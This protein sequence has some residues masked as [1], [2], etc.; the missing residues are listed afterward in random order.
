MSTESK[1]IDLGKK[2]TLKE[3]ISFGLSQSGSA[4]AF[5]AISSLVTIFWTD[6]AGVNPAIIA[7]VIIF[8]KILDAISNIVFGFLIQQTK[9]KYG[10]ARPWLLWMAV[11]FSLSAIFCFLVPSGASDTTQWWFIF[12]AYNFV[13]TIA[14]TALDLAEGTLV[15][16]MSRRPAERERLGSFRIGIGMIGHILAGGLTIPLIHALGNKQSSWII[17]MT[18]WAIY[19]CVV[20]IIAFVNCKE[21]V[22]ITVDAYVHRPPITKQLKALFSNQYWWWCLIFW[23]VWATQYAFAGTTMTY[24]C[25]YILGND[26]LYTVFF[27]TEKLVWGICILALPVIRRKIKWSVRQFIV[28]GPIVC[29]LAHLLLLAFPTSV[30]INLILVIL[31]G[32]GIACITAFFHMVVSTITDFGQYKTHQRQESLTFAAASMGEK[33]FNGIILSALTAILAITGFVSSSTGGTV[34]P[35]TAIAG[36]HNLYIWGNVIIY[37]ALAIIN[38]LY[39]L[40]G[41]EDEL[42]EELRAREARGEL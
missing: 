35:D 15:S 30:P 31:R 24:Y 32:F 21:Q 14:Y 11:P 26:N 20:H 13:S 3:Y 28:F 1:T 37:A 10:Q 2:L 33:I 19:A 5:S 9:S 38:S 40:S 41:R 34:Q 17:I 27:I 6:Y 29:C 22:K 23:G 12:L 4:V 18:I 25:R 36:I 8:S 7:Q 42:Q 39:R 16:M